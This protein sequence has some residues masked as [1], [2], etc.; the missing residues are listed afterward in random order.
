M[1]SFEI[2]VPCGA[3]VKVVCKEADEEMKVVEN[4]KVIYGNKNNSNKANKSEPASEE[5]STEEETSGNSDT[6]ENSNDTSENMAGGKRSRRAKG[7]K[8]NVT[9]KKQ[10]GGKRGPNAYMKFASKMRPQILKEHPEMKS[11]VVAVARKIGEKW[12]ALSA[13][14]K[15]KY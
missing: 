10:S 2:H 5:T 15:A 6:E 14:E 7:R 13:S 11:D 1:S 8:A 4:G 12:R 3:T 9:R